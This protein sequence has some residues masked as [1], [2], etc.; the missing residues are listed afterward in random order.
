VITTVLAA[1]LTLAMSM[2][3]ITDKNMIAARLIDFVF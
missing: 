3:D 2:L 1:T